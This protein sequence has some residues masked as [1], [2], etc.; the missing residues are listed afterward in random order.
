MNDKW[1]VEER[2]GNHTL[3]SLM[4]GSFKLNVIHCKSRP[5]FR[6]S[7]D[8]IRPNLVGISNA[9]QAWSELGLDFQV[10]LNFGLI[11]AAKA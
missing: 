1:K 3:G 5:M 10:S 7:L 11:Q 4:V 6:P 9:V 8:G 2:R